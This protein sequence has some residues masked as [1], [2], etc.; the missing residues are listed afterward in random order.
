M[1]FA[2]RTVAGTLLGARLRALELVRDPVVIGVPRGGAITA[3]AVAYELE[4]PLDVIVTERIS[5]A[6]NP[7]F[8][9]ATVDED[10]R[11]VTMGGNLPPPVH[12]EMEDLRQ[13]V[14]SARQRA[15]RRAARYRLGNPHVLLAGRD[16]VIADDGIMTGLSACAAAMYARAHNARNIVIA[17]PV[18]SAQAIAQLEHV[19]DAV[20]AIDTPQPMRSIADHY[21]HFSPV[22]DAAVRAVL[23]H[24]IEPRL[25]GRG[26]EITREGV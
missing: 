6:A 17:A 21:R 11:I 4:A 19:A 1:I 10:G 2:N 9:I 7:S 5:S 24:A 3:S 18:A 25:A 26:S 16:V 15:R 22:P 23:H 8:P 14:A 12:V 13:Q 20:I